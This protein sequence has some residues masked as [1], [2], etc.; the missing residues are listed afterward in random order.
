[1]K[2]M[3]EESEQRDKMMEKHFISRNIKK[4]IE[5]ILTGNV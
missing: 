1:M 4:R 5:K 2:L 3:M